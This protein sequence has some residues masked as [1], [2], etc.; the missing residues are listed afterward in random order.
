[1]LQHY[2]QALCSQRRS[3][4]CSVPFLGPRC[5]TSSARADTHTMASAA[6][7]RAAE[8]KR[9]RCARLMN[10]HTIG[11]WRVPSDN[12]GEAVD[13]RYHKNVPSFDGGTGSKRL[14][15]CGA[16]GRTWRAGHVLCTE[17]H[18]H[19]PVCLSVL[20]SILLCARSMKVAQ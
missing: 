7:G 16:A 13:H 10:V 5:S 19:G 20:S 3:C 2:T 12:A 8:N 17:W 9:R 11:S 6:V 1:M 18:T 14:S 15:W 4:P